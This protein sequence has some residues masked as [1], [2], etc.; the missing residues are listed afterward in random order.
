MLAT[1]GLN[2][3]DSL[4]VTVS[5]PGTHLF[6]RMIHPWMRSVVDVRDKGNRGN[7]GEG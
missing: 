1:T 3:G 7:R 6:Q 5:T 2:P 4:T